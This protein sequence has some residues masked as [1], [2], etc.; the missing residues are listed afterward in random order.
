M[1]DIKRYTMSKDEI[2]QIAK[3]AHENKYGSIMLQ[4]GELLNEQRL[5]FLCDVIRTIRSE[6]IDMDHALGRAPQPIS[7]RQGLGVALSVGELPITHYR[8]LMNAGAH[9][10][11]LRIESSNPELYAR[12]HPNDELHS[13]QTRYRCIKTLQ[14]LGF[15]LGT[16]VMIGLPTQTTADQARDL[17]WFKKENVDMIGMGPYV[18]EENTPVG[19]MW[20]EEIQNQGI[21]KDQYKINVFERTT[22]M[23]ALARILMGDI[24][25]AATTALQAIRPDGREVA[26][27]RGANILMPILT[28]TETREH[29]QLYEGKPCLDE[30]ATQC[31][32][33]L[34]LRVTTA[35]KEIAWGEWGDPVHFWN[36]HSS[37]SS[38]Q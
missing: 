32:S 8:A 18:Y 3:W 5:N 36:T 31:R 21:T 29:Y 16:G 33:C 19:K 38:S 6:T 25:I 11:L 13:W 12:L 22:R 1:T 7:G 10:Y 14:H 9:R 35:G 30:T 34:K 15:Q 37:S 28:P 27:R 24:N 2:V 23:I 4:S 20:L 26:L 17:L